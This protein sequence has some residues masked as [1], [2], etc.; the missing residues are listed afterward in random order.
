[1]QPLAWAQVTLGITVQFLHGVS[2]MVRGLRWVF[3]IGLIPAASSS[4]PLNPTVL[5]GRW[6]AD[7]GETSD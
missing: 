1:M 4:A 5:A 7:T 3:W 2:G 6:P